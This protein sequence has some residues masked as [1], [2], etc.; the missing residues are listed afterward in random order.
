MSADLTTKDLVVEIGLIARRLE[1][2]RDEL[3]RLDGLIGDGDHGVAMAEGFVAA[4]GAASAL[5]PDAATLSEV[6]TSSAK[7]FLN[8]VGASSGPLY[9][10]ALLRAAKAVGVGASL[11]IAETPRIVIAMAEGVQARGRATFGEK[12]MFDAWGKAAEAAEKGL[13]EGAK[14]PNNLHAILAAARDGAEATKSM[15]GSKGRAAR[16]GDRAL[17]HIDP[18]AASAVLIIETLTA[19]WLSLDS[20]PP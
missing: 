10:T 17:G 13:A 1:G 15:I 20:S 18:G 3:C 8:A 16:L 12:T 11:P 6:L 9:A 4:A 19:H 7:S 14:L 2:A 5:D